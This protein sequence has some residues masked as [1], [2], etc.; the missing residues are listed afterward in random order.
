MEARNPI[1]LTKLNGFCAHALLHIFLPDH[2]NDGIDLRTNLE[3]TEQDATAPPLTPSA[4][5]TTVPRAGARDTGP[6]DR[7]FDYASRAK[8]RKATWQRGFRLKCNAN[9]TYL[10]MRLRSTDIEGDDYM[11]ANTTIHALDKIVY[12]L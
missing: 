2:E 6:S 5:L 11:K 12:G 1:D 10:T 7:T 3:Y 4:T 8:P 9:M